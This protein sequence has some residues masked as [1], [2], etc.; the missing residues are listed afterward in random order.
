MAKERFGAIQGKGFGR[1]GRSFAIPTQNPTTW[2]G[3]AIKEILSSVEDFTHYAQE[4]PDLD[5]LV[6][7]IGTGYAG[8]KTHQIAPLFE[9]VPPNVVLPIVFYEALKN[10][11]RQDPSQQ[12]SG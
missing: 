1:Q 11:R 4:H 7:P 3:L 6:T 10:H 2:Q 9:T 5:F 8:Y 12:Y